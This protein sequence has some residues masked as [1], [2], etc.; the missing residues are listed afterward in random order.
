[1]F[2]PEG[3]CGFMYRETVRICL[4]V[5][6]R[7]RQSSLCLPNDLNVVNQA[8]TPG[9]QINVALLIMLRPNEDGGTF[10]LLL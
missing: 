3:H 10:E 2:L 8:L 1:M 9:Q 7:N 5:A 6:Y 4:R